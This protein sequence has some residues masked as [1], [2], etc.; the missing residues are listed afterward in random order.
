MRHKINGASN[1]KEMPF[2]SIKFA[3]FN[4]KDKCRHKNG[5]WRKMVNR[6]TEKTTANP[7]FFP[8][9][10]VK[11]LSCDIKTVGLKIFLLKE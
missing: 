8:S 10:R 5:F 4:N 2:Y 11:W 6:K 9:A 7:L 3:F 1:R